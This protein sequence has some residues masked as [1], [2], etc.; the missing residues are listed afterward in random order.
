MTSKQTYSWGELFA[1]ADKD[2]KFMQDKLFN[3]YDKQ[4]L[5]KEKINKLK[6]AN[7]SFL[8]LQKLESEL[9]NLESDIQYYEKKLY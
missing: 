3:L 9:F 5:V 1:K 2:I 4:K 6:Q 8:E 7:N